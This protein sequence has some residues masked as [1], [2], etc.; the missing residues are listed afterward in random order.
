MTL[1]GKDTEDPEDIR[2]RMPSGS[3]IYNMG[4]RENQRK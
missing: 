2:S 1:P 4:V 3:S